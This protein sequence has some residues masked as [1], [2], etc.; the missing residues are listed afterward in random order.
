MT[1]LL[2]SENFADV[3]I[4][5]GDDKIP[6]HKVI[7]AAHSKVLAKMIEE[8]Q[9]NEIV[10]AKKAPKEAYIELIRFI[11]NATIKRLKE[12]LEPLLMLAKEFEIEELR[13]LCLMEIDR[14]INAKY[15]K[16]IGKNPKLPESIMNDDN[17]AIKFYRLLYDMD[18]LIYDKNND[19]PTPSSSK[20]SL[21]EEEEELPQGNQPY[22]PEASQQDIQLPT[23]VL[24]PPPAF[25]PLISEEIF[26]NSLTDL[27]VN[28][29]SPIQEQEE[30]TSGNAD[31][32]VEKVEVIYTASDS[33]KD[34]HAEINECTMIGNSP[35]IEIKEPKENFAK[36]IE[37]LKN[38]D[39]NITLETVR[40]SSDN[41]AE[42][43]EAKVDTVNDP[44][45]IKTICESPV[46]I[47][48]SGNNKE[49]TQT[50]TDKE[51]NVADT[52][53]NEEN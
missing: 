51:S 8:S 52:N 43:D 36:D 15:T 38:V 40:E 16:F 47:E 30:L 24:H 6:A 9:A 23:I 11:Y 41:I 48:N 45:D 1:K 4:I 12:N 39:E 10:I 14:A 31:V 28:T 50:S 53:T 25:E 44:D 3:T 5:I 34:A 7:L 26:T 2:M 35:E 13:M 17:K 21:D 49:I 29:L 22:E 19:G 32:I 18:E 20:S 42:S 27:F 46:E 33:T 37:C